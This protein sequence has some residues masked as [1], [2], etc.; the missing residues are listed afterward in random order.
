M[1]MGGDYYVAARTKEEAIKT[2]VSNNNLN[3]DEVREKIE[4][5]GTQVIYKECNVS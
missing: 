3:E 4:T 1:A 2:L 5:L